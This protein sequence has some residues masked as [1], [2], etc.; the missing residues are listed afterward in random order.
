MVRSLWEWLIGENPA[1][2]LPQEATRGPGIGQGLCAGFY[3]WLALL[4]DREAVTRGDQ[5]A[6]ASL[7]SLSCA[8]GRW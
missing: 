1:S 5:R 2:M 3:R 8:S 7:T 6:R 4:K